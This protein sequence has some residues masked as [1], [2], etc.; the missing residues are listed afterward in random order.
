MDESF[1]PYRKW[2]GIP[3][4]E[5][6]PHHYRLLGLELFE[7]DADVIVNAA[8][9]RMSFLRTLSA[10]KHAD[11]AERI[12]AQ[13]KEAQS[14]LLDPAKKAFYD[15]QLKRRI[16]A[17]NKEPPAMPTTPIAAASPSANSTA[18]IALPK[19]QIPSPSTLSSRPGPG[20][21]PKAAA[22]IFGLAATICVIVF[23]VSKS[24]NSGGTPSSAPLAQSGPENGNNHETN[25]TSTTP[26]VDSPTGVQTTNSAP[27]AGNGEKN[28]PPKNGGTSTE[29]PKPNGDNPSHVPKNNPFDVPNDEDKNNSDDVNPGNIIGLPEDDSRLRIRR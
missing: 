10:D 14:C 24:G 2:L 13:I 17:L 7:A 12:V 5:Q 18:N 21:W 8:D 27:P 1:D 26:Q 9:A 15:G 6:P 25:P 11:M 19:L 20:Q 29:P 23:L 16:A 22:M 28:P 4:E 3:P